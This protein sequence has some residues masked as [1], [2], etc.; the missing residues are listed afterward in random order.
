MA[1]PQPRK[2]PSNAGSEG[3]VGSLISTLNSLTRASSYRAIFTSSLLLCALFV[4][5]I[6]TSTSTYYL[7]QSFLINRPSL[8]ASFPLDLQFGYSRPPFAVV[9]LGGW[10]K[11]GQSYDARLVLE[12]PRWSGAGA[13][14]EGRANFMV[15]LELRGEGERA[16]VR[17]GKHSV[18]PPQPHGISTSL[19]FPLRLFSS[20]PDSDVV[21]LKVPLLRDRAV[22]E[23]VTTAL[24]EVGREDEYQPEC[25]SDGDVLRGRRIVDR[26]G[27]GGELIVNRAT[28]EVVARLA[29]MRYLMYYHPFI[30]LIFI[31]GFFFVL[32]FLCALLAWYYYY[33]SAGMEDQE[34]ETLRRMKAADDE[35]EEE[36]RRMM[37]RARESR[38]MH[39]L[40]DMSEPEEPVAGPSGTTGERSERTPSAELKVVE[41]RE[42]RGSWEDLGSAEGVADV[43]LEEEEKLDEP[44]FA[45]SETSGARSTSFGPTLQS[46]SS[47]SGTDTPRQRRTST[48]TA[49]V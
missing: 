11:K 15:T 2:A 45:G 32:Q 27:R 40:D 30:S 22:A 41:E 16:V 10:W 3:T 33:P 13:L 4:T 31:G 37:G 34:E 5:T 29:G 7:F 38:R 28:L 26:R 9:D 39:K 19:S 46:R 48:R 18:V 42:R 12:V 49:E 43:K 17:M 1:S 14:N 8:S 20:R 24:V 35:E 44:P 36:A 21:R 25:L 6:L 23:K 47:A